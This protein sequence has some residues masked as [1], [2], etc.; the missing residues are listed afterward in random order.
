MLD[1]ASD[2]A[3]GSHINDINFELKSR[4]RLFHS[5]AEI[6]LETILFLYLNLDHWKLFYSYTD[7]LLSLNLCDLY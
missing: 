6:S 1:K 4:W 2:Q 3:I 7:I 5:Y